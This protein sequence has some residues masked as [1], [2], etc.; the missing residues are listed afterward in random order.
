MSREIRE[1]L[2]QVLGMQ[3]FLSFPTRSLE[4]PD[5]AAGHCHLA[6]EAGEQGARHL[7]AEVG[8]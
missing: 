2:A 7:G 6:A 8:E 3:D 4:N 5:S 1:G